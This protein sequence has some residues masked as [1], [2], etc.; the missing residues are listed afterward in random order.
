[1]KIE[2][3]KCD[4]FK[5]FTITIENENEYNILWAC[6]NVPYMRAMN[7]KKPGTIVCEVTKS[8]MFIAVDQFGGGN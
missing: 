6:L 7:N 4:T 8:A 5:P 2:K 3:L 1:M